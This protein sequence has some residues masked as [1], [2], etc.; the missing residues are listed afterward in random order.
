M[1]DREIRWRRSVVF[2]VTCLFHGGIV[3]FLVHA[4]PPY[5]SLKTADQFLTIFLVK[6]Q[7]A[8]VIALPKQSI[9]ERGSRKSQEQFLESET[10]TLLPDATVPPVEA[11][12]S[13]DPANIDWTGEAQRAAEAIARGTTPGS[14]DSSVAA[15]GAAPWNPHPGRLESTP[16]GVK[17]RILDPCFALL[18]NWTHDPLL[19]TKGEL[20]LNCN[21]KTP[22]PRGDLFDSIRK[23]PSNK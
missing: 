3:F 6:P 1:S 7:P 15:V 21:W 9:I 13:G 20:Q 22:P 11:Q 5:R 8:I 16:E 10:L 2:I 4:K 23:P 12:A 19:G 17:L 18:H 14:S